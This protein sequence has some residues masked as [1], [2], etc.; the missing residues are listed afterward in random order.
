MT[1]LPRGPD[2]GDA[3]DPQVAAWLEVPALDETTR[4]RLVRTAAT[5][6][7]G[8]TARRTRAPGR[9]GAAAGIA[10]A[11]LVGAVVGAVVVTSP[12]DPEVQDAARASSTEVT[13]AADASAAPTGS[14]ADDAPGA[15]VA[16][17][18]PTA[19]PQQLGDL[20]AAGD[21][22]GLRQALSAAFE[23]GRSGEAEAAAEVVPCGDLAPEP[24][25]LVVISAVAEVRLDGLPVVVAVGPAPDGADLAVAVDP[26]RD[27]AV[28][29]RVPL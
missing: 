4:R 14:A 23:R 19:P 16:P 28:V 8:T 5:A 20:G 21:V 10:A 17:A 6:R 7:H 27:C 18:A 9:L 11:L 12:S 3:R 29:E 22:A 26:G 1:D 13:S 25:G 24:L 2:L 15:Q